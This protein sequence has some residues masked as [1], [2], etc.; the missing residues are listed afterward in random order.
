VNPNRCPTPQESPI[1]QIAYG[2]EWISAVF[3]GMVPQKGFEPAIAQPS[4]VAIWNGRVS[5]T[6]GINSKAKFPDSNPGALPISKNAR[7]TEHMALQGEYLE[8]DVVVVAQ[9][10]LAAPYSRKILF[11]RD[12]KPCKRGVDR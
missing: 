9:D 3:D 6:A 7:V 4:D 12:P 2:T 10:V 1:R 5:A 11:V 8:F